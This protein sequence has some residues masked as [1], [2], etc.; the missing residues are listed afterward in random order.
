ML[1]LGVISDV[2]W[3]ARPH[4]PVSWH[5]EFDFEG[6]P[7]RVAVAVERFFADR[8]DAVVIAGDLGEEGDLESTTALVEAVRAAGKDPF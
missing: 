1:R 2:H 4:E 3:V 7:G 6:T 5:N 8:V